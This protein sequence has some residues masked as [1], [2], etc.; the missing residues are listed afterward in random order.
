MKILFFRKIFDQN[1]KKSENLKNSQISD[2]RFF[3]FCQFLRFFE[4]RFFVLVEKKLKKIK[5][6]I[7][8]PLALYEFGPNFFCDFSSLE[9]FDFEPFSENLIKKGF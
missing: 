7:F 5:K 6:S 1:K 2:L 4:K 9:H 8:S 3:G